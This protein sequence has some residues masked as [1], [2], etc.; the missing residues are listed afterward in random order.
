MNHDAESRDTAQ[1]GGHCA[2]PAPNHHEPHEEGII[3]VQQD[4]P[5]RAEGLQGCGKHP[6]LLCFI[7]E[8]AYQAHRNGGGDLALD[9][10][11]WEANI[12]ESQLPG[13]ACVTAAAAA[14]TWV[15]NALYQCMMPCMHWTACTCIHQHASVHAQA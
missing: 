6:C 14:L 12:A 7:A 2:S 9:W 5:Q 8:G 13:Y 4:H 3:W 11:I 15:F 1:E 10:Y